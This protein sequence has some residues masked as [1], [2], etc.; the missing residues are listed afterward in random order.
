[1]IDRMKYYG[2]KGK[3]DE[4]VWGVG[5]ESLATAVV[6]Q[7]IKDYIDWKRLEYGLKVVNS[8]QEK[9]ASSTISK[10]KHDG[11]TAET[12][13]LKYADSFCDINGKQIIKEIEDRF[14]RGL[15]K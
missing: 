7:A 4:Q 5:Y 11:M 1:M 15:I 14:K 9:Y 12:Y 8:K 3:A 2:K 13:I 6:I 10:I